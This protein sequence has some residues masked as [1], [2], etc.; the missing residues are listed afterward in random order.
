MGRLVQQGPH[1]HSVNILYILRWG[2]SPELRME[3]VCQSRRFCEVRE[4]E[5]EGA[6]ER[7]SASGTHSTGAGFEKERAHESGMDQGHRDLRLLSH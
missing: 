4:M 2:D 7:Q 1:G 6:G 3:P 5:E